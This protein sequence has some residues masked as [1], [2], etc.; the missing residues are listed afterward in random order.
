MSEQSNNM[1]SNGSPP[2]AETPVV[3]TQGNAPELGQG[4]WSVDL[5]IPT[6]EPKNETPDE[7]TP[8][9]GWEP[10]EVEAFKT[11]PKEI[12]DKFLPRY[13][14]L[15]E[16]KDRTFFEHPEAYRLS[17]EYSE[18]S[19][20]LSL[21]DRVANHWSKQLEA[22]ESGSTQITPI[23]INDNGEL[24]EGAPIEVTPR[25]K[26]MVTTWLNKAIAE[27]SELEEQLR[28]YPEQFKSGYDSFS[29]AL[30]DVESRL[31]SKVDFKK[32][33]IAKIYSMWNNLIPKQFHG[34][35]HIE[36]IVKL[37]TALTLVT[38]RAQMKNAGAFTKQPAPQIGGTPSS[39]AN[40]PALEYI[41][42][43][44]SGRFA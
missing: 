15:R 27:R 8:P 30:K 3:E 14:S 39:G 25:V 12:R 24:T 16:L 43:L 22:I 4:D 19:A 29:K 35:P 36:L 28:N 2:P 17:P 21:V 40:D 5:G 23:E 6:E 31:F 38:Q 42:A 44:A 10:D 37:A 32:P 34:H 41:K 1:P 11:L 33:E 13:S 18:K 9:E 26:A 7:F 20:M